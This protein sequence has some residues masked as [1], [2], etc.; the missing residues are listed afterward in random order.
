MSVC[1]HVFGGTVFFNTLLAPPY[2]GQQLLTHLMPIIIGLDTVWTL[3][4]LDIYH[5]CVSAGP[6]KPLKG[7]L[8]HHKLA[9]T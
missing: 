2:G 9:P 3:M 1:M 8:G 5:S 6:Y 4:S 7:E